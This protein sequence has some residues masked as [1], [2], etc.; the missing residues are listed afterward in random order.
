[1]FSKIFEEKNNLL[2]EN[3][4][5]HYNINT[6]LA[7][8][9][10]D[11]EELLFLLS[12]L[13]NKELQILA[14][15]ALQLT[16]KRFGK[17]ISFYVPLYLSN[18]CESICV[19]CGFS[20]TRKIKRMTLNYS[21]IEYNF[22]VLQSKGFDNI[23]L[24]TGESRK[25]FGV[26]QI[27]KSVALAKKYFTFVAIEVF[28]ME[29]D[30]YKKIIDAGCDGIT[31]YQEVYNKDIYQKMHLE[32]DKKDYIY[33]LNT[34]D[35]ALKAGFRKIGIG[36]LLG[37]SDPLFEIRALATHV[38]YLQ[39]KYWRSEISLSF[40]RIRP[41]NILAKVPFFITDKRLIQIIC[42]LRVYFPDVSFVLSTRENS[43]IRDHLLGLGITQMS[44]E[45]AT[46]PDGYT[47]GDSGRQFMISDERKL[48][49]MLKVIRENGYDPVLKDWSTNFKGGAL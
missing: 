40:P 11:Q 19:Y 28:A 5:I 13:N 39:K 12:D 47:G 1:M 34:P 24:V 3:T 43:Q 17:T 18:E 30:E 27:T 29:E 20:K 16:I 38:R 41:E 48:N 35:R 9:H 14:Q 49:E 36:V 23:L 4:K 7:K 37:L 44:A 8:D 21:Q 15:K 31:I 6:I 26:E 25:L 22:Q 10:L 46:S 2:K 42:A 45:S 33:R 32:G